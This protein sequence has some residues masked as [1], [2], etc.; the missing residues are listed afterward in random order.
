MPV[1]KGTRP[2]A[3]DASPGGRAGVRPRA[4]AQARGAARTSAGSMP[5]TVPRIAATPQQLACFR[6]RR[7][8]ASGDTLAVY[9]PYETG[10]PLH[11]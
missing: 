11:P 9:L 5:D 6:R 4:L 2:P 7:P 10:F 1:L 3:A 8:P